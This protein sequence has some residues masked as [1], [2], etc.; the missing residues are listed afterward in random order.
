MPIG[1]LASVEVG[2]VSLAQLVFKNSFAETGGG[3]IASAPALGLAGSIGFNDCVRLTGSL[4][5]ATTFKRVVAV[6]VGSDCI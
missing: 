4:T 6:S 2:G 3:L 1:A 5:A